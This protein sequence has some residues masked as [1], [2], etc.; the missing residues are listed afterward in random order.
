MLTLGEDLGFHCADIAT[1]YVIRDF[2]YSNFEVG[3]FPALDLT[4]KL[5]ELID[6]DLY[7]LVELSGG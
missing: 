4:N 2:M 7:D 5:L 1:N 3:V 6:R